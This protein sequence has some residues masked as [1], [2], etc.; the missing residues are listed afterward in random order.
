M[1]RLWHCRTNVARLRI[2]NSLA[3]TLAQALRAARGHVDLERAVPEFST[4][5]PDGK[6]EIAVLDV[7]AWFLGA[8]EWFPVDVTV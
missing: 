4:K 3:M 7:T 1:R 5:M 6:I 2:H 8:I